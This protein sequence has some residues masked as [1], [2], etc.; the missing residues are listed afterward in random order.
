MARLAPDTLQQARQLLSLYPEPRSAL[1]PLCHLAQAQDGW[2]TAEAMEHIAELL[3]LTAAEVYGTATFYDMLHTEKVG[4]Y[5]IGVCTNIACL[6][7]GGEELLEHASARLGVRPGSTS[8]DGRFTLEEVEC[9]AACDRAPCATVNWRYFGPLTPESF[10][11]LVEDLSSGRLEESVPPH[12]VL[13]RVR[14]SGGLAV[15]AEEVAS[16]R[17]AADRAKAARAEAAGSGSGS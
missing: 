12:G 9:I 14:R 8:A 2:L 3:G 5:L 15:S 6:L 10:D 4:R 1:I 13:S 16:E 7:D 11:A 17:V